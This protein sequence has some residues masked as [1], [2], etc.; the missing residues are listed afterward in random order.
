MISSDYF[1]CFTVLPSER[2]LHYQERVL[3][4]L[5]SFGT[6]SHLLI[7]KHL[8][9]DAMII[10]LGT[11]T[12][13]MPT[14][15]SNYLNP[16]IVSPPNHFILNNLTILHLPANKVD[17]SKQG[18]MKFR[19]ERSILGL[20]TGSFH[21]RY[22]ILNSNSLRMYKEVRVRLADLFYTNFTYRVFMVTFFHRLI[23]SVSVS[24]CLSE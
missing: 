6:D 12:N 23:H 20:S 5:H 8:A 9:M 10:Y 7:K 24:L 3:P 14:K 21:D 19:E 1:M 17:A 15:L 16:C 11:H 22:F 2:P 4:I 18:M 13:H